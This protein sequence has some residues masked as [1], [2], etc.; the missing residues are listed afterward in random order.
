MSRESPR[1]NLR[2]W[3]QDLVFR[4]IIGG[5]LL[6]PYRWRVPLCGWA[7]SALIAPLAGYRRR[8]RE[9]LALVLPELPDKEVR[10]LVRQVPNNIGRSLIE[11]YSGQEFIN[12][13]AALPLAGEGVEALAGAHEAGQPVV[14]VTAHIGN[15]DACRAA[16]RA[17]GYNVGGLYMEM[18]NRFFNEHYVAAMRQIGGPVF[19]RDRRGM[20][21]MVRFLRDGGMLGMLVDQ[22]MRSGRLLGFFGH[23]A[24]TALSAAEL[25]LK[26]NALLVPVYAIRQEDGL[27]FQIIIESPISHEDPVTMT[28]A[29]NDSLE[30]L[31]RQHMDQWFWIHRRWR[32]GG[33][34]IT[35]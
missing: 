5:L 32:D 30:A 21:G 34:R 1:F 23:E 14:L 24:L 28:Q 33:A 31:V 3:L 26:Y 4:S 11:T 17:R 13:S 2:H 9:N 25:A 19:A 16:L 6:L 7:V 15:Y 27:S 18:S 20:A 8:I 29:L 35:G 22:R 10:R 12:R